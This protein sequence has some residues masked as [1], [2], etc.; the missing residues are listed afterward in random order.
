MKIPWYLPVFFG[1][2]YRVSG[3]EN[4]RFR[5]ISLT[6]KKRGRIQWN[7]KLLP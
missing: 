6:R 5:K 7:I 3:L 2:V 4:F 1:K